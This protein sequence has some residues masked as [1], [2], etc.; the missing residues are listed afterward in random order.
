[1]DKSNLDTK[2]FEFHPSCAYKKLVREECGKQWHFQLEQFC[3]LAYSKKGNGGYCPT[4]MLLRC[5]QDRADPGILV[6]RPMTNFTKAMI[7]SQVTKMAVIRLRDF[8]AIMDAKQQKV[9][10]CLSTGLAL[11]VTSNRLKLETI[12]EII[13]LCSHQNI[14]QRK[15]RD[16]RGNVER[17]PSSNHGNF[18]AILVY[19][20]KRGDKILGKHLSTASG[21]ATY[22]SSM[23]QNEFTFIIGNH[24]TNNIISKVKRAKWFTAI[25]AEVTD[26]SNKEQLSL[27]LRYVDPDDS[28]VW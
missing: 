24:I 20:V 19:A 23:I 1:M 27:V 25:T 21:N 10:I 3:W 9:H 28:Q 16:S 26:V 4:C 11:R 6:S 5:G 22:T 14:A 17:D 7:T 2:K 13:L 15:H 8:I 18:L 12:V